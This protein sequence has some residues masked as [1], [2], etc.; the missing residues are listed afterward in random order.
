MSL[1]DRD[2]AF[3]RRVVERLIN[4]EVIWLTTVR[5]DGRALPVPVWFYWDGDDGLLTYSQPKALKLRNIEANPLVTL[6]FNS[7][8]HGDD[9]ARFEA[10]AWI[11]LDAPQAREIPEL[12]E[13]YRVYSEIH[14]W[15]P[16]RAWDDY[17][18]PIRLRLTKLWGYLD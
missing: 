6:N 12:V 14:G 4:E 9:V 11:D 1:I 8:E 17:T 18:V 5:S 2:S 10:E 16:E 13:K 3:G 7:D 15:V